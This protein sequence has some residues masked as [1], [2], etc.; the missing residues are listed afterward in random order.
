MYYSCACDVL[1]AAG[2]SLPV[3]LTLESVSTTTAVVRW[4]N[5]QAPI[6][7]T[8]DARLLVR[9]LV[10][11][12]GDSADGADEDVSVRTVALDSAA[13]GDGQYYLEQLV[14]GQ[15]YSA[16]M[17]VEQPYTASSNLSNVLYFTTLDG[18]SDCSC[19]LA[20]R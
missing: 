12:D 8:S 18:L 14:D 11:F 3:I 13:D 4:S 20:L 1:F 16:Q 10:Q 6:T 7:A 19:C 17:V 5:T 2:E 15:T 9:R